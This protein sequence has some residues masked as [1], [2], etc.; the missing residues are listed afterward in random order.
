MSSQ[1]MLPGSVRAEPGRGGLPRLVVTRP[2][3]SAEIYLQGAHVTAWTPAGG[4]PVL[5]MS[6]HSNFAPGAAIRG[7]VPVC[8]PWFGPDPAGVGPLHGF[9]RTAPWTLDEV[10]QQDED[11]VL[12]LSLGDADIPDDQARTWP[13]EF[14]ARY[15][16]AVGA[17]LTL[18]LE[19]TNPGTSAITFQ[20]A[21]HTYLAVGDV[22]AATIRGLEHASYSDRLAGGRAV[23]GGRGAPDHR[24]GNRQAVRPAR[25]D[26]R[27]GPGRRAD[28]VSR[29][30][31]L[32][33]R[34]HLEPVAGQGGS[35][36]RLRERRVDADAVRRDV[37]CQRGRGDA[38][39]GAVA[40]DVGP[41]GGRLI[42]E[43][44]RP[45]RQPAATG[46][47]RVGRGCTVGDGAGGTA[48]R[49]LP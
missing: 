34:S 18:S 12:V 19:V 46:W 17:T 49:H 28:G 13:D 39:A 9:A 20:E 42:V 38:R 2:A 24:R 8:F 31:E 23:A 15:T 4:D 41:A 26:P 11:V 30:Q 25:D 1:F 21:F 14:R 32:G 40:R 33:Q 45:T 16:V 47:H 44:P 35:H 29:S 22:G 3:G 43:H 6:Q 7:G 5:W 36:G 37:Q 27:R 48:A 10:R